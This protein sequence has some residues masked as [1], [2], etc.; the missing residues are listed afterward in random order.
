MLALLYCAVATFRFFF[1]SQGRL[2]RELGRLSYNVYIIHIGVMG[3]IALALLRI[4]L[5]G[6]LKYPILTIT[7]YAACNLIAYAYAKTVKNLAATPG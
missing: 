5:P 7:T 1:N 6:I 4:D 3:L 2:G